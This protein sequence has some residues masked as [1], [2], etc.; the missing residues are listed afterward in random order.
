MDV[1]ARA[2]P[3]V[4]DHLFDDFDHRGLTPGIVYDVVSIENE[5]LRVVDDFGEPIL[6]PDILFDVVDSSVCPDWV[7]QTC[8]DGQ[9]F[10]GP[11]IFLEPGFFE[12]YFDKDALAIK[13]FDSYLNEKNIKKEARKKPEQQWE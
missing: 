10:V 5:F 7:T 9:R 12:H 8:S 3:G 2:K 11:E 13:V 1:K 4:N 6:Y